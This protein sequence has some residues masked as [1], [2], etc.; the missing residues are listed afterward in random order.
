MTGIAME[1]AFLRQVFPGGGPE[2][3]ELEAR[4]RTVFED[5]RAFRDTN[6]EFIDATRNDPAMKRVDAA[7]IASNQELVQSMVRDLLGGSSIAEILERWRN[8]ARSASR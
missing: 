8:R 6:L 5:L 7:V 1:A 3:A 4:A 2:H